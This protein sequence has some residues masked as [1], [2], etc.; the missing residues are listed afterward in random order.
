MT[1][2][3]SFSFSL[4]ARRRCRSIALLVVMACIAAPVHAAQAQDDSGEPTPPPPAASPLG[5]LD[6]ARAGLPERVRGVG[7]TSG[8]VRGAESR[9]T[10]LEA[11]I[12]AN[13]AIRD[14]ANAQLVD[15]AAQRQ[16]QRDRIDAERA[17]RQDAGVRAARH[18]ND[19]EVLA[20]EAYV[21]GGPDDDTFPL[22]VTATNDVG[23]QRVIVDVVDATVRERLA[24]AEADRDDATVQV[25]AA[26][27]ALDAVIAEI[28]ATT[29][30][31][32]AAEAEL[33]RAEPELPRA[34]EDFREAFM[35]AT[36]D[37]SDMSV[38]AYDAY[39]NAAAG[40]GACGL[41]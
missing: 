40:Q 6:E 18:R 17:R 30:R 38:V 28:V 3:P 32:D 29:R 9:I 25:S 2:P 36:L 16:A 35:V 37:G 33:S 15:L 19:L 41:P 12:V 21:G 10:S 22:D 26:L 20:V 8:A 24:Q 39:A 1:S 23:R 4:R 34:Q 27:A 11:T 13:R 14:E 31:R 5:A 7:A